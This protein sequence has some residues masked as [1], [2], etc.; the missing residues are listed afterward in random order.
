MAP[1]CAKL[2]MD[3]L[4][5]NLISA[6]RL[7]PYIW[8]RYINDIFVIWTHGEQKRLEFLEQI[9]WSHNSITF[10]WEW[11]QKKVNFLDIQIINNER[12][13][14]TDVYVEPTDKHQ[15]LTYNSCHPAA[16]PASCMPKL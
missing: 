5:K 13:I 7:K 14:D 2:F 3:D 1:S 11:S 8:L 15:Y 6:A 10:T 4:E 9:N 12:Q 16:K